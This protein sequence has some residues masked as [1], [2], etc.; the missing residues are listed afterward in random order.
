MHA[1]VYESQVQ[2]IQLRKH[3]HYVGL[4]PE[5]L[6]HLFIS[7]FKSLFGIHNHIY[8]Y[9]KQETVTDKLVSKHKMHILY[10][11]CPSKSCTF[12]ITQE[13]AVGII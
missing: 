4:G 11:G 1:T 13:N 7:L 3:G 6:S 10:E 8:K 9:T 2:S 12:F 5:D